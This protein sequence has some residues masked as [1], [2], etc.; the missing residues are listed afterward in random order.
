[1]HPPDLRASVRSLAATA[2]FDDCRVAAAGT[3]PHA[4]VFHR[5]L[6]DGC[7]GT[8]DWMA[9]DPMRRSDPRLVLPGCR[10]VVVLA[11]NYFPGPR[12]AR[13]EDRATG[14]IARYAW[15]L[16]YHDLVLPRLRALAASM[17]PWGG[18]QKC[19]TD[20]GPV[21]ERDFASLAGL[22]WNG[23]STVQIH[24]RLG[25]WFFLGVILTTLEIEPDAPER[26]RCGH[27]TRCLAAC[28]TG[29]LTAPHRLEARLCLSYLTIEHK[30]DFPVELRPLLGDRI[31]GCDDCLEA[32][33][34]NRF[35]HTARESA[36]L[37]RPA[38]FGMGLRDFLA[39]D[40]EGFRALFRGSPV[41]RIKRPRFLRNVCVA[42]GNTGSPDDAPAL[43]QAAADPDPLIAGH[44]AWALDRLAERFGA[45]ASEAPA[46]SA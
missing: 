44:A 19:Y 9:R 36:F 30:G 17:E 15:N 5:W 45:P 43:R 27:C 37:A 8:M 26:D 33:P 6:A 41:K 7:H 42:L 23:K 20:T 3:A 28:P 34:W 13:P 38:V 16:D 18:T 29:A 46:A 22:G 11:L 10:S 4:E 39:L 35:A 32:C 12:P 1:M 31:F 21:L 2:G 14:R 24:P 40:D 25:T